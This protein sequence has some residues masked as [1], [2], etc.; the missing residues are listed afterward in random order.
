MAY[1]LV[2]LAAP[3]RRA[4]RLFARSSAATSSPHV[5][6]MAPPVLVAL[7]A[8]ARRPGRPCSLVIR[9]KEVG[10]IKKAAT[11]LRGPTHQRLARGSDRPNACRR[12]EFPY[13]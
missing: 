3:G 4:R 13:Y 8:H 2:D 10:R 6:A 1:E 11:V 9:V 7:P 12:E 5:P